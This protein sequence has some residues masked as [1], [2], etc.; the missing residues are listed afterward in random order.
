MGKELKLK[1]HAPVINVMVLDRE[2]IP[3]A[4][5]T[6]REAGRA[7]IPDM[8][9]GHNVLIMSEEQLKIFTLPTL[10]HRNKEKLTAMDGSRL[11]K[12]TTLRVE[13]K[14]ENGAQHH[15]LVCLT[16]LGDVRVY[17]LPGLRL[18]FQ[19]QIAKRE[20][21]RAILSLLFADGGELFFMK[22]PSAMQRSTILPNE[23]VASIDFGPGTSDG[24]SK[25]SNGID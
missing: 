13:T 7:T 15:C 8:T 21:I 6:D 1:H 9:G 2:G 19:A 11:R 25:L 14:G 24:S 23:V 10:R 20:D 4:S 22:S 18:Q 17:T 16:N 3:I 5:R 12:T